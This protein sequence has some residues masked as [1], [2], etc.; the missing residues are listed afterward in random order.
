MGNSWKQV[1]ILPISIPVETAAA[2]VFTWILEHPIRVT[3][4]SVIVHAVTAT[5]NTATVV[6][7]DAIIA[8]A[9]RA[10]KATLSIPDATA[11]GTEIAADESSGVTW[12]PFELSEGDTLIVEQKVAGVDAGT[13]AGDYYVAI[14]YE[15]MPDGRV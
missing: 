2:D 14:Y 8:G 5:D 9:A 1:L 13:E 6:S 10:E 3:D 7:F 15:I 11:I 4:V 12:E